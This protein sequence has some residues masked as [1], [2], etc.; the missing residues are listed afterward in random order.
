ML[1]TARKAVLY[2]GARESGRDIL[3]L[4]LALSQESHSAGELRIS[5][6]HPYRR[7]YHRGVDRQRLIGKEDP[8]FINRHSVSRLGTGW[9]GRDMEPQHI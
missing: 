7:D 2:I 5:M 1:V 6:C 4:M 8:R 3:A 9:R